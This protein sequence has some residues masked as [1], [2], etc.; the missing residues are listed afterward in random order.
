MGRAPGFVA[1]SYHFRFYKEM[2][3]KGQSSPVQ[4]SKKA[5]SDT[6]LVFSLLTS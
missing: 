1:P 5:A 4:Q 6:F 2:I 3:Y